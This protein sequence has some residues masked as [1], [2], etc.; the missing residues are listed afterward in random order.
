[1]H[2]AWGGGADG[3]LGPAP[4][5]GLLVW[6]VW[7]EVCGGWTM[8]G[9]AHLPWATATLSTN[10]QQLPRKGASQVGASRP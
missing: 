8:D 9:G 1:M 3:N 4:V 6:G 10:T 7:T 5:L 2:A